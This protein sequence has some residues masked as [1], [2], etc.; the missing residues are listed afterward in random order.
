MYTDIYKDMLEK[1]KYHKQLIMNAFIR[2]NYYPSNEEINAALAKVNARLSLF[3]SYISKPGS[4]FNY[5]EINY[6]FEMIYKDLE[7]LYVVLE[8]ILYNEYSQLKLQ[9]E[10]KLL[11]LESKASSFKQRCTEEANSTALGTTIFFQSNNWLIFTEDQMTILDLGSIDFIEG[12]TIACFANVND[13]EQ[14]QVAFKFINEDSEK[15]FLALPYNMYEN[16]SYKIPGELGINK[17]SYNIN[18]SAIVDDYFKI[19]HKLNN[20]NKYKITGGANLMAVTSKRTGLTELVRFPNIDDYYYTALEECFIEFYVVDGNVSDASVLEYSFNTRPNH[21]NFDLQNGTI[22][23]DKDIKRI[24][25]DAQKGLTLAFL[26][27]HGTIYAE[28]IDAVIVDKDNMLYVGNLDIRDIVIRE[29]VRSNLETYNV[30]VYIN[31]KEDII[32]GINSIYIKELS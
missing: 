14:D 11:E 21:C 5:K 16:I 29:Y 8:N 6:C 27:D 28:C 26:A 7:L 4:K 23:I 32:S 24:S 22:K 31:S 13:V 15:D 10:S 1:L 25:I 30:K 12:Q 19:E 2:N 3:E 20:L 9:I 18:S 17:Y